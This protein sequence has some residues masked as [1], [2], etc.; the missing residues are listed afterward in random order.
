[1]T[2]LPTTLSFRRHP[3]PLSSSLLFAPV[4]STTLPGRSVFKTSALLALNTLL[5]SVGSTALMAF[6]DNRNYLISHLM[7]PHKYSTVASYF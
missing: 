1:M 4:V 2:E 3:V 7:V 5:P 6:V